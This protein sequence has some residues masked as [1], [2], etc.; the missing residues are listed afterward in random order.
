MN[1]NRLKDSETQRNGTP[2]KTLLIEM[3]Y[4]TRE[5]LAAGLYGVSFICA[6]AGLIGAVVMK[7]WEQVPFTLCI[8]LLCGA[9]VV[10]KWR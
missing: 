2:Q 3:E 9:S 10:E 7:H 4:G 5:R 1:Y 8:T 6:L